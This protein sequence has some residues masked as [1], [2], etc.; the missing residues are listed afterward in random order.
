M[1]KEISSEVKES[2][3]YSSVLEPYGIILPCKYE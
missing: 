3:D 2:V 1:K